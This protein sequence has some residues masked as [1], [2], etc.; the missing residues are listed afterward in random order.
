MATPTPSTT[1]P[2]V[3]Y[4]KEV[5]VVEVTEAR[6][7]VEGRTICVL[8]VDPRKDSEHDLFK[9]FAPFGPITAL[10]FFSIENHARRKRAQRTL[11]L[12]RMS[13]HRGWTP[14]I[15]KTLRRLFPS[16]LTNVRSDQRENVFAEFRDRNDARIAIKK[17]AEL[18]YKG[19]RLT[20][21]MALDEFDPEQLGLVEFKNRS[22]ARKAVAKFERQPL[23]R[24]KK[25]ELARTNFE[26]VAGTKVLRTQ[27]SERRKIY[28]ASPVAVHHGGAGYAGKTQP[29]APLSYA[30]R[31]S[32]QTSPPMPPPATEKSP[33]PVLAGG[34]QRHP[35]ARK[36]PPPAETPGPIPPPNLSP[37]KPPGHTHNTLT[38][39][40]HRLGLHIAGPPPTTQPDPEPDAAPAGLLQ[41][42]VGSKTLAPLLSSNQSGH[43]NRPPPLPSNPAGLSASFDQ[44]MPQPSDLVSSLLQGSAKEPVSEPPLLTPSGLSPPNR[45][46]APSSHHCSN[47]DEE[48]LLAASSQH[49]SHP[50]NVGSQPDLDFNPSDLLPQGLLGGRARQQEIRMQ[51]I[52]Q[53]N[54]QERDNADEN[55]LLLAASS[56]HWHTENQQQT[57]PNVGMNN[58]TNHPHN[59]SRNPVEPT[60]SMN[61]QQMKQIGYAQQQ[62][63]FVNNTIPN[64]VG[65][66]PGLHQQAATQAQQAHWA[67]QRH[68]W[69]MQYTGRNPQLHVQQPVPVQVSS[70]YT[71]QVSWDPAMNRG[72]SVLTHHVPQ[73]HGEQSVHSFFT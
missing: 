72:P 10:C 59:S 27:K 2:K 50:P 55:L 44:P 30:A 23:Q 73:Q 69:T 25:V 11:F 66:A 62:P 9:E 58:H 21:E 34:G 36:V 38:M 24:W 12:P 14:W 54:G 31:V 22:D 6:R 43:Q 46:H 37:V 45:E 18:K 3:D 35:T 17:I 63:M 53:E 39:G 5:D 28:L 1:P 70:H 60:P 29:S 42:P 56:Q 40:P 13:A 64:N 7:T 71:P 68:Q 8:R 33:A 51:E 20:P 41:A 65:H 4:S 26:I 32:L 52:Q 16:A 19:E 47:D 48:L 57:T 49:S 61:P 15:S 67:Q